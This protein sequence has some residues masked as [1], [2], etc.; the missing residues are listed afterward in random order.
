MCSNLKLI[1]EIVKINVINLNYN[2]ITIKILKIIVIALSKLIV[3]FI[4]A[5]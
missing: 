3:E 1:C 5:M 2:K 4:I